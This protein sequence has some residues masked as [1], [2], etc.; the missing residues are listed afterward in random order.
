MCLIATGL[1]QYSIYLPQSSISSMSPHHCKGHSADKGMYN[2]I[3]MCKNLPVCHII[4][5]TLTTRGGLYKSWKDSM[6][7]DVGFLNWSEIENWENA[8]AL[9][10]DWLPWILL[11]VSK[12]LFHRERCHFYSQ[13]TVTDAPPPACLRTPD[14]ASWK[15]RIPDLMRTGA[16]KVFRGFFNVLQIKSP[17]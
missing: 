4:Q 10:D 6:K 2:K 11:S 8:T 5:F 1:H 17:Y 14:D 9:K 12:Y 7:T 13:F 16:H 15:V 3:T